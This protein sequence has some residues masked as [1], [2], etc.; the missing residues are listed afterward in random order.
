[1]LKKVLYMQMCFMQKCKWKMTKKEFLL[2]NVWKNVFLLK[3]IRIVSDEKCW[4]EGIY[5]INAQKHLW[6]EILK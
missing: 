2:K 1:M 4:K 5:M 6:E 3:C